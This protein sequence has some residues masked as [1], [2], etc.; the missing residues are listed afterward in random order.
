[1]RS[2]ILVSATPPNSVCSVPLHETFTFSLHGVGKSSL[3]SLKRN[4]IRL[5]S[6]ASLLTVYEHWK[7]T[8]PNLEVR[9]VDSLPFL[10]ASKFRIAR[11]AAILDL[12]LR[13]NRL[14]APCAAQTESESIKMPSRPLPLRLEPL[15]RHW[16]KVSVMIPTLQSADKK[17]S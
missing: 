7:W 11:A 10:S 5:I 4:A 9:S 2:Q 6:R 13:R 17:K 3:K 1:M 16:N 8:S 15:S 14:T 12:R